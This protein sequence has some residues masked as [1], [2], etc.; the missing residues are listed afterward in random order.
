[1]KNISLYL[2]LF[3]LSSSLIFLGFA[4]NGGNVGDKE[5]NNKPFEAFLEIFPDLDL[6]YEIT[7][8]KLQPK[9]EN[10]NHKYENTG[11]RITTLFGA[12]IPGV[13]R[14]SFS[15]RPAPSY[16]VEGKF[17]QNDNFVAVIY[18]IIPAFSR[19]DYN[20]IEYVLATYNVKDK[21][22]EPHERMISSMVIGEMNGRMKTS[23]IDKDFNITV[24]SYQRDFKNPD[25]EASKEVLTTKTYSISKTGIAEKTSNKPA[26]VKEEPAIKA[27]KANRAN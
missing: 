22:L 3:T 12:F 13:S 23:Q 1:M 26:K 20:S 4:S 7:A 25:Q 10:S 15:R 9:K 27:K 21:K 19:G 24:K 2:L 14:A 16:H 11:K 6:P 18:K 8:E 5:N 17:K